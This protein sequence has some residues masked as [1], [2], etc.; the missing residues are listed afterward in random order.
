MGW[1]GGNRRKGILFKIFFS[2]YDL[3]LFVFGG[4][5]RLIVSILLGYNC[6]IKIVEIL[7]NLDRGS[8]F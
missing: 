6:R 8:S 2:F 3:Y 4:F 1:R 5:N 7:L